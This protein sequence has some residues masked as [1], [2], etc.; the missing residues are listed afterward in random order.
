M[1]RFVGYYSVRLLPLRR[2]S[3]RRPHG[4]W[5]D[6]HDCAECFLNVRNVSDIEQIVGQWIVALLRARDV[7]GSVL[8]HRGIFAPQL[9]D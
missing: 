6:A 9:T 8:L 4:H 1:R 3:R 7:G 2:G 5:I